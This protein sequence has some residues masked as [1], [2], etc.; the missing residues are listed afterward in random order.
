MTGDWWSKFQLFCNVSIFWVSQSVFSVKVFILSLLMTN[1]FS[2]SLSSTLQTKITSCLLASAQTWV[3]V[4]LNQAFSY[5]HSH[6]LPSPNT[7]WSFV[8]NLFSQSVDSVRTQPFPFHLHSGDV[9]TVLVLQAGFWVSFYLIFLSA[10]LYRSYPPWM[11]LSH[12]PSLERY[13]SFC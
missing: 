11:W 4:I 3:L 5:L 13:C 12:V 9:C 10:D 6:S 1:G 2:P 8:S 7:W